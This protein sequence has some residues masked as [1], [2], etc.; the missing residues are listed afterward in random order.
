MKTIFTFFILVLGLQL[1]AET[2]LCRQYVPKEEELQSNKPRLVITPSGSLALIANNT[3]LFARIEINNEAKIQFSSDAGAFNVLNTMVLEPDPWLSASTFDVYSNTSN[4]ETMVA[5]YFEKN[6]KTTTE[7]AFIA[8]VEVD[9]MST[10]KANR[11][12]FVCVKK[13]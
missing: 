12:V 7:K 11:M 5:L 10:G 8:F 1:Q 9:N 2:L 4:S 6:W 13:Q 3:P